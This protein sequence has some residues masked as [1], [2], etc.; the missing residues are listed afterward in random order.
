MKPKVYIE[1]SIPSF[2]HETRTSPEAVA[3]RN[4]TRDWWE[5][6]RYL[7]EILSSEAVFKELRATPE[8]KHSLC[9]DFIEPIDFLEITSG[10]VLVAEVYVKNK[11]MPLNAAGDALHLAIASY[12]Q[13][14]FL[15]TW[16]CKHLANANKAGHIRRINSML[17]LYVPM[18]ITPLELLG[19][20][21]G[22]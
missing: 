4:W 15:L 13:C 16:N 3:R 10:I 21:D 18:L 7:Y 2:Y 12:Y 11:L 19:V 1:T 6:K 20:K 17:G 14:H 9:I 5:S 22:D 8:P